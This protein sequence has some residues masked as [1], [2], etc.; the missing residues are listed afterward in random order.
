MKSSLK[1]FVRIFALSILFFSFYSTQAQ[2]VTVPA[3]NTNNGSVNDPFGTYW[4]FERS[5]MIYS[6]AQIGTTGNINSVGFYLNSVATPGAG[7]N[8][9]IYMKMRTTAFT[10]ASA[11]ATETTGATLVF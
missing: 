9:R 8:V 2:T 11:Y 1:L 5:A 3:A 10:A 7:V 4:G 6:S